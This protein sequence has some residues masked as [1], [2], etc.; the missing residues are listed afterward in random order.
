MGDDF[1][2]VKDF[3]KKNFEKV[4]FLNQKQVKARSKETYIHCS[5]LKTL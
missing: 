3:A 5:L 1:L 4:H 2:K